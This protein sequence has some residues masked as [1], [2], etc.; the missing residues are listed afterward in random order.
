MLFSALKFPASVLLYFCLISFCFL[1]VTLFSILS[2][3]ICLAK[4]SPFFKA[5]TKPSPFPPPPGSPLGLGLVALMQ[6]LSMAAA[7]HSEPSVAA[8]LPWSLTMPRVCFLSVH[9]VIC[10]CPPSLWVGPSTTKASFS[11][12][13][14]EGWNTHLDP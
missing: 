1:L 2:S 3:E 6:L 12:V 10:S 8:V 4:S 7:A 5:Q 9:L 14:R 11:I 13:K